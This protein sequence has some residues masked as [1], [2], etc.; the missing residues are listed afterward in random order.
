MVDSRLHRGPDLEDAQNFGP[1]QLATLCAAVAD[2]SWLL[3]HGYAEHSSLALVGNRYSLRDRQRQAVGRCS[4]SSAARELRLAHRVGPAEVAGQ[5]VLIDGFNVLTTVELALG[6]GVLLVGCDGVMRDIVG[7]RGSYR[8]VAE[9]RPAIDLIGRQ[10]KAFGVREARWLLDRPVSNRGRLRDLLLEVAGELGVAWTVMLESN[11]DPE[12]R[13][14]REIVATADS[15]IL[16]R[17][18]R[19]FGLAGLVVE[20]SVPE[21]WVIKLGL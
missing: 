6:G 5:C 3:D 10:L 21:A 20:C 17:C 9:T 19:W 16:E 2:L 1:D 11:P 18:L 8:L 7:L 4:C 14:S 15:A 12:L 13:G